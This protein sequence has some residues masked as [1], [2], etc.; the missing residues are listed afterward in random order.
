L[1]RSKNKV[2]NSLIISLVK[3][4]S[5]RQGR[6][7]SETVSRSFHILRVIS[8]TM[9]SVYERPSL[10]KVGSLEAVTKSTNTGPNVDAAFAAQAPSILGALS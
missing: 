3:D 10:T 4:G 8:M 6:V 1:R 5:I 7:R 2:A 9:K